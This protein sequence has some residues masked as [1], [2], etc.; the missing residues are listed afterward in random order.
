MGI[1][2][3]GGV[4]GAPRGH[5]HFRGRGRAGRRGASARG[6]R[7]VNSR[8]AR[9]NGG[10]FGASRGRNFNRDVRGGRGNTR[11]RQWYKSERHAL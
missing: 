1:G 5:A 7:G 4:W 11:G 8:G 3:D 9:G 2:R 6:G 10:N